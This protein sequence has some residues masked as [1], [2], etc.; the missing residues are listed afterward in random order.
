MF[1]AAFGGVDE[2]VWRFFIDHPFLV[3]FAKVYTRWGVVSVLTPLALAVGVAIFVKTKTA[4][5]AAIPMLA[6][7][8][9]CIATA[10]LKSWFNVARPP[11][12]F[13]LTGAGHGSF[14]SGHTANTTALVIAIALVLGVLTGSRSV[15]RAIYFTA[16]LLVSLMGWSRLALNVHWFSDVV[17]GWI[18]GSIAALLTSSILMKLTKS[19]PTRQTRWS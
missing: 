16:G 5:L 4:T 1:A 6:L 15:Q 7:Q 2:R 12:E 18:L 19:A 17:A 3:S 14:P 10:E 8:V 9:N 13:W 11:R